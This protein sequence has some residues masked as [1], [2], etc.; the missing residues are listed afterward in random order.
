MDWDEEILGEMVGGY[1]TVVFQ[2]TGIPIA[3]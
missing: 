3:K 2:A 1:D